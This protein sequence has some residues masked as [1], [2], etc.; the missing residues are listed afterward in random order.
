MFQRKLG[1][2]NRLNVVSAANN[3]LDDYD[4]PNYDVSN[5]TIGSVG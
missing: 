3:L 1:I 5:T 2:A 4:L